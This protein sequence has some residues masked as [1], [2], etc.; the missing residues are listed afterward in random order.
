MTQHH[1]LS[2]MADNLDFLSNL[3]QI[4]LWGNDTYGRQ[5][6][7]HIRVREDW[8]FW[9]RKLLWLLLPFVGGI[10][11]KQTYSVEE[12]LFNILPKYIHMHNT[13]IGVPMHYLHAFYRR[14]SSSVSPSSSSTMVN[15]SGEALSGQCL[16]LLVQDGCCNLVGKAVRA[17]AR[18]AG[19]EVLFA[20]DLVPWKSWQW[21]APASL[22]SK[23]RQKSSSSLVNSF[24]GK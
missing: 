8:F 21:A 4:T 18:S 10:V 22:S 6:P 23:L 1:H 9:F 13:M 14:S 20:G 11:W 16:D 15:A 5:V 24:C 2:S 12:C 3:F 17:Q 7:C 19:V